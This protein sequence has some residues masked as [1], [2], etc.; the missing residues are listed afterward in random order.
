MTVVMIARSSMYSQKASK[1]P[2]AVTWPVAPL[3]SFRPVH[4]MMKTGRPGATASTGPKATGRSAAPSSIRRARPV[5]WSTA[6]RRTERAFPSG[7]VTSTFAAPS[8]R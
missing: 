6:E 4:V 7:P 2:T 5:S 1:G 3:R 8:T